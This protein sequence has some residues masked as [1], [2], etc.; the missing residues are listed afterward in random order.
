LSLSFRELKNPI[1]TGSYRAD[2]R[3]SMLSNMRLSR[4]LVLLLPIVTGC[5]AETGD[6]GVAGTEK[7]RDRRR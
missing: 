5:A 6:T 3:A 7:K 1:A 2:A 4:L